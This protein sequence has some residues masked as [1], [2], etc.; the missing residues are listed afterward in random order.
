[1]PILEKNRRDD[2]ENRGVAGAALLRTSYSTRSGRVNSEAV[3][4]A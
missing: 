1:M 4:F 2:D 3:P